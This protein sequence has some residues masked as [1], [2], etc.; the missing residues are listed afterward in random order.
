[1]RDASKT[2]LFFPCSQNHGSPVPIDLCL[3]PLRPDHRVDWDHV[4]F[5]DSAVSSTLASRLVLAWLDGEDY[6]VGLL[7]ELVVVY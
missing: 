6:V 3:H 1:M 2:T 7:R 4:L 5:L